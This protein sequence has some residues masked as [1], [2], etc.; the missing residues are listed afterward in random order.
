MTGRHRRNGS[1]NLVLRWGL[2]GV[3]ASGLLVGWAVTASS[4]THHPEPRAE[5]DHRHVVPAERYAEYPR[6]ARTYAKVAEIPHVI[7]GIYCYC[8]CS[9]HSGHHSLLDCFHDDHGAY[10]DICLSQ[11]DIAHR[12]YKEE[13]KTLDEIREA[14]DRIYKT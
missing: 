14:I 8:A 3:V 11:A 12:M 7:D 1:R 4:G 5:V 6:V 2:G 13:G 10:C 9:E